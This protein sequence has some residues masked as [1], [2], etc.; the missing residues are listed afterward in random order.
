[1]DNLPAGPTWPAVARG[2]EKLTFL[3]AGALI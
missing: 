3:A 1:M 2:L